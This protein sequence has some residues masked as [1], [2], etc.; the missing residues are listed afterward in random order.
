MTFDITL[1]QATRV[2]RIRLGEGEVLRTK[3][4][5]TLERDDPRLA[6]EPTDYASARPGVYIRAVSAGIR[7]PSQLSKQTVEHLEALGYG[8]GEPD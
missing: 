6:G 8:A 3:A 4:P 2:A 5:I 7:E 1:T